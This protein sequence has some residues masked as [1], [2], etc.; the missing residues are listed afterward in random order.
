M[1]PGNVRALIVDGVLD[2]IAWTTGSGDASTVPFSTRL[3][4]DIGAQATL[5]EFFRLCDA[6]TCAL[7]R[8]RRRA[9]RRLATT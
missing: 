8:A 5:E 7:A 6:G 3:H 9:S 2:P 1:F 4:S